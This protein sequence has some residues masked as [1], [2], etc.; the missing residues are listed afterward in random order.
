M[1]KL[2]LLRFTTPVYCGV[3]PL[4]SAFVHLEGLIGDDELPLLLKFASDNPTE[5]VASIVDVDADAAYTLSFA[6]E[7]GSAKGKNKKLNPSKSAIKT[8]LKEKCFLVIIRYL[9][10]FLCA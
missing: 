5:D 6:M 7:L 1:S 10:V 9:L 8:D 2:S 3:V 4:P